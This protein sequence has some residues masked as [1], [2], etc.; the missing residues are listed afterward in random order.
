MP[1]RVSMEERVMV[2]MLALS[3]EGNL[4]LYP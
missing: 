4:K 3:A 1:R 2:P